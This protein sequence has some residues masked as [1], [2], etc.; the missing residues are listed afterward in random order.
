AC[1]QVA[2]NDTIR[3]TSIGPQQ[4][5]VREELNIGDTAIRVR[6]VCLYGDIRRRQKNSSAHWIGD[7]H[8]GA[9]VG[10]GLDDHCANHADGLMG[11][12]VVAECARLIEL[13]GAA[14]AWHGNTAAESV[15]GGGLHIM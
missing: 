3:G 6:G 15:G 9:G 8:R 1:W 13:F 4:G 10:G 7:G 11:R 2:R 12:T 5:R 14:P